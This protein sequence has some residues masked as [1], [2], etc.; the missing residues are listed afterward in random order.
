MQKF[1]LPKGTILPNHIAV[2]L[3]GNGRWA[4][5]RGLPTTKGHEAGAEALETLIKASRDIGIHTLTVWGFST[6]NWKRP[7]MEIAKIMELVQKTIERNLAESKKNGV[8]FVHLGS[9]DRLPRPLVKLLQKAEAE[10]KNNKKHVLNLAINYGGRDEMIRATKRLIEDK[11]PANKITE[12]LF[13]SYL[14]TAGQPY[15]NPDLLIRTSGEQRTSGLMPWQMIYSEFYFEED[16]LPD[17]NHEKLRKILLDYS[18]RRRRFGSKDKVEHF[19]FQPEVAA[20]LELSWWRL[21][22]IPEDKTF[23]QYAME[24]VREQWG[25]SVELAKTASGHMVKGFMYGKRDDWKKARM[26]LRKF[27]KLIRDEV[28]LAF[29]P[30]IAASLQI[31]IWQETENGK[32]AELTHDFEETTRELVTEVYRISDH[33][34]GKVAHLRALATI[35]KNMAEHGGGDEH[36]E[37]AGEYLQLYYKALKNRVA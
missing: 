11:V 20:R 35:E 26:Y 4:R 13:D 37:K 24:H 7:P 28:R 8:R 14:D 12:K 17:M 15:P 31:K 22:K 10:T 16:H 18:R 32:R 29:E 9:K 5:A 1:T 33:Q 3:D 36:W 21:S 6:E 34:A 30:S 25:L 2:I 19:K 27:Y 23:E